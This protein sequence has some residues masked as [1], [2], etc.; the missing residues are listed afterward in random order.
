MKLYSYYRSTAAYRVRIALHYKRIEHELIPVDLI[1]EQH[2]NSSYSEINPQTRV[3]S[4]TDGDI[5][6]GQSMAILEY[7][8]EK[9]PHPSLLPE[10]IDERAWARYVSQ[11]IVSDLHPLNNSGTLNYLRSTMQH[12]QSEL[13]Q[14]YHYWLRKNFDALEAI[15]AKKSN[16]QFCIGDNITIADICLIPQIYNAFRFDF[17]MEAY[18]TL[19]AINDHCLS[20]PCFAKAHPQQQPDYQPREGTAIP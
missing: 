19:L 2:L 7:L 6:I 1:H 15:I 4:L 14:W 17:A 3:P 13:L 11:I 5:T 9:Y 8:E 18:P 16:G 10:R 12:S 20:L